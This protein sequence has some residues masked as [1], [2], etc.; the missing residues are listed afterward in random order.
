MCPVVHKSHL[1][2]EIAA[3]PWEPSGADRLTQRWRLGPGG[4]RRRSL[5][6][7]V[8]FYEFFGFLCSGYPFPFFDSV[9]RGLCQ[10]RVA[11]NHLSELR[12]SVR[13]NHDSHPEGP[14]DLRS[15]G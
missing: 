2:N 12:L 8:E 11:A 4:S 10:P 7:K 15:A 6:M 5:G 3:A 13:R 1:I 9:K 14:M